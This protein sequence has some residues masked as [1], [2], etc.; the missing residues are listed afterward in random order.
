MIHSITSLFLCS[1]REVGE[2]TAG[3]F[4]QE[5]VY[6]AYLLGTLAFLTRIDVVTTTFAVR[7]GQGK[8]V[9]WRIT[10]EFA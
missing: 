8:W 3:I 6:S 5:V 2:N 7:L 1:G 4:V 10:M 9:N